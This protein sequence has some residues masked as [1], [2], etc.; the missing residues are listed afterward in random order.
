[1]KSVINQIAQATPGINDRDAFAVLYRKHVDASDEG[2]RQA[3]EQYKKAARKIK[4]V[5]K[6]KPDRIRR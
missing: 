5:A 3:F 1:M 2:V 6:S 4:R